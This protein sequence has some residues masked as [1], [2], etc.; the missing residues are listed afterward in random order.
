MG[1]YFTKIV[2]EPSPIEEENLQEETNK[3]SLLLTLKY[4]F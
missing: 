3:E 1:K 4:V 2:R